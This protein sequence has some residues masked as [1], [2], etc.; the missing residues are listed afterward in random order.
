MFLDPGIRIFLENRRKPRET[1]GLRKERWL[2][3]MGNESLETCCL[4]EMF[5]RTPATHPEKAKSSSEKAKSSSETLLSAFHCG[6]QANMG[7]CV[8]ILFR[9]CLLV[10]WFLRERQGVH[11]VGGPLP[12]PAVWLLPGLLVCFR[13]KQL[14]PVW[15]FFFKIET[16]IIYFGVVIRRVF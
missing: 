8:C 13:I 5:K 10:G 12:A 4:S 2:E 1:A 11:I 6:R 15:T 14:V 16:T 3:R 7:V 9:M